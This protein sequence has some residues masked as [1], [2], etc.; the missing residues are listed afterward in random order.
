MPRKGSRATDKASPDRV[1]AVTV[2]GPLP[3]LV[4]LKAAYAFHSFAY[5]DPR[6][7]F[8]SAM[9]LPVVSPTAV[10]LGIASTLFSLGQRDKAEAFLKD[11]HQAKVIIDPPESMIFFRA[12]HQIRRYETDKYGPNPRMGLT[13][14]NQGT[15]EYGLPDGSITIYVG[16]PEAHVKSTRLALVNRDHLGTHD[17]LCSLVGD[18]ERCDEP[19]DVLYCALEGS[20]PVP[21]DGPLTVVTLSR[22]RGRIRSTVGDHWWMAGGDDTELVP[23]LI[24]GTFHGT[25]RGKIYRKH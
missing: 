23:Y 3:I 16:V 15:R 12:F 19:K 10:L 5:R 6:S 11:A 17:S 7:A 20:F 9:G 13:D 14:I 2:V 22:F 24:K 4:W 1:S 25:S 8:S 21:K 18:V